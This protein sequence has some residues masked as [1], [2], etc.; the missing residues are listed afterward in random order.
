MANLNRSQDDDLMKVYNNPGQLAWLGAMVRQRLAATN[1]VFRIPTDKADVYEVPRF[2]TKRD[3]RDLITLINASA[4]PSTLFK[5]TDMPGF[6]TSWTC[7]FDTSEPLPES[8][9][10]YICE[11]LGINNIYAETMQGQRYRRGQEYKAHHDFFHVGERYWLDEAPRGGQR[12][13]TAMI[14]LN[15]PLGGGQTWFPHLD[16]VIEPDVGKLLVWNNMDASGHPNTNTLHAAMP[17]NRGVKH[18]ITKWFRLGPWKLL[19]NA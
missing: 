14:Y 13:W 11:L 12:T 3:C 6:R 7:H 16:L 2:L 19:N 15:K 8:L 17:V 18:V 5:G 9:E 1:G 10:E 4:V